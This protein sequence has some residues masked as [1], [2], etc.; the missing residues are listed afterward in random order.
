MLKKKTKT[1]KLEALSHTNLVPFECITHIDAVYL[2]LMTHLS[3]STN[4]AAPLFPY[5]P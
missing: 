3:V 4:K 2:S 1:L 5:R